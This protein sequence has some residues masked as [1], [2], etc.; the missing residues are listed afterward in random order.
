M[1]NI[2]TRNRKRYGQG[3]SLE[4]S[5]IDGLAQSFAEWMTGAYAESYAYKVA[6]YCKN[7]KNCEDCVFYNG[8][9]RIN[10]FPFNWDCK[11]I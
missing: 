2:Y 11:S 7:L 9:C 8:T 10:D 1:S 3:T 6:E 4:N 5:D